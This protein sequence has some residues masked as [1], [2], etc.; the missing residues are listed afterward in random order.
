MKPCWTNTAWKRIITHFLL[1]LLLQ[2]T[3]IYPTTFQ[4]NKT[5]AQHILV[6]QRGKKL[7]FFVFFSV[8][9]LKKLKDKVIK[10]DVL[11]KNIDAD[12]LSESMM[13]I[14]LNNSRSPSF[15]CNV[16]LSIVSSNKDCFFLSDFLKT[17]WLCIWKFLF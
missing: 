2:K 3:L 16:F 4:L 8:T 15:Y 14:S 17:S 1:T 10:N 9:I 6:V 11:T 12:R 7:L 5:R 13:S